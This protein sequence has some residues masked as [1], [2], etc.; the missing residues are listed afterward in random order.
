MANHPNRSGS[1]YPRYWSKFPRQDFDSRR[2]RSGW[3]TDMTTKARQIERAYA[4]GHTTEPF[5]QLVEETRTGY[6]VVAEWMP[7]SGWTDP[8]VAAGFLPRTIV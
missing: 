7:S 2:P 6:R 8:L 3:T 1:T 4:P 5:V